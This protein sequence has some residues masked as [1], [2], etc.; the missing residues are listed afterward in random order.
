[1]SAFRLALLLI[2]LIA[3]QNSARSPADC[4]ATEPFAGKVLDQLNK[5]Q[6]QGYL[7]QLLQVADAH[8]DKAESVA[9]YYLVWD[10]KESDCSVLSGRHWDDCEPTLSKCVSD[11]VIGQCKVIAT[12][13]LNDSQ[14]FRV[15]DYNCTTRSV[16]SALANTKDSPVLF[17]FLEEPE[18]YRKLTDKALEKYQQENGDFASFRVDRVERVVRGRGE[19]RTNYYVDFSVR[20]CSRRPH[21]PRHPYVFGFCRADL[22]YDVGVSDL[23]TPEDIAINC[24]VFNFEECRNISGIPHH[25]GHPHHSGGHEH[26]LAG[27]PPFKPDE[28]RDHHHPHR[29]HTF[30]CP[31]LLEDRPPFQ[32]QDVITPTLAPVGPMDTLI[33]VVPGSTIPMDPLIIDPLVMDPLIKDPLLMGP[34]LTGPLL[35]DPLLTGIIPMD[36]IPMDTIPMDTIPM[37]TISLTMGLVTHPPWGPEDHQGPEDHHRQGHGPPSRHSEERGPG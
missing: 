26:S 28:F 25:F 13:C 22:S 15:N 17:D 36:T 14:H 10:V 30:E 32:G 8:V 5:G 19:E 29:P 18:L 35:T 2:P 37:D 9:V 23:E 20:N 27:R 16:S 3:L 1:M 4:N 33:I 6:R 11:T 34:C 12:Q 21:F 24:E 7:F 31:P